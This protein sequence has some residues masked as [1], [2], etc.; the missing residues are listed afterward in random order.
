[1]VFLCVGIGL[2]AAWLGKKAFDHFSY[3]EDASIVFTV[4]MF[5]IFSG[6][7]YVLIDR[8]LPPGML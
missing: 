7:S 3:N 1:M 2:L 8:L 6:G 5:F 4:A